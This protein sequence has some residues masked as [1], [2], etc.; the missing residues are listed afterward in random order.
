VASWRPRYESKG[1][2]KI[3]GSPFDSFAKAEEACNT[4][5]AHLNTA[6]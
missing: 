6:P 4:M 5:L 2:I 3:G 1:A